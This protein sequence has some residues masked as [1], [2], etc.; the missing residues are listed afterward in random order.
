MFKTDGW[1]GGESMKLLSLCFFY[2]ETSRE[3]PPLPPSKEESQEGAVSRS[4]HYGSS[5][6]SSVTN[7]TLLLLTTLYGNI[8]TAKLT[9]R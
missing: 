5:S 7:T 6:S 8:A 2:N 4:V 9:L 3:C 1:V